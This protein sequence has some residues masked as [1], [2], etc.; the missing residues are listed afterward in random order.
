MGQLQASGKHRKKVKKEIDAQFKQLIAC[1][2]AETLK[3]GLVDYEHQVVAYTF[4]KKKDDEFKVS[5]ELGTMAIKLQA[6]ALQFSKALGE[7]S[8]GVMHLRGKN[9]VMSSYPTDNQVSLI[10]CHSFAGNKK[11]AAYDRIV[12][13]EET[14]RAAAKRM[15]EIIERGKVKK[16]EQR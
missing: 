5:E 13:H 16:E 6:A 14:V 9:S 12:K 2:G 1:F 3:A 7:D 10:V 8:V 11:A 15:G 4:T